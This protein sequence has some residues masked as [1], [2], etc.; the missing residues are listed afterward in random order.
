MNNFSFSLDYKTL[1]P[2][3][4]RA[5]VVVVSLYLP[6]LNIHS[7]TPNPYIGFQIENGDYN[8]YNIES[9]GIKK[10]LKTGLSRN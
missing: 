10:L 7:H 9:T 6:V 3:Y 2:K 8:D 4:R 1:V 5:L